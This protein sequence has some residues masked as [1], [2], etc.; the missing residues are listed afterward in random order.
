MSDH[1]ET[2]ASSQKTTLTPDEID[3]LLTSTEPDAEE[4]LREHARDIAHAAMASA[5]AHDYARAHCDTLAK[6][7]VAGDPAA[8]KMAAV[9][10]SGGKKSEDG[11]DLAFEELHIA[12][13]RASLA[14]CGW[15]ANLISVQCLNMLDAIKAINYVELRFASPTGDVRGQDEVLLTVQRV[16][17]PTP[18]ELRRAAEDREGVAKMETVRL[19]EGIEGAIN[20]IEGRATACRHLS[21]RTE[22]GARSV[23]A[24]AVAKA[25]A[26][27]HAVELPCA[28]LGLPAP[29]RHGGSKAVEADDGDLL[30]A[31][32]T[33]I[34]TLPRCDRSGCSDFATWPLD[35]FSRGC[36]THHEESA[37]AS[38]WLKGLR[39]F[40]YAPA[41][42]ALLA[43][44]VWIAL[45][46]VDGQ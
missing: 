36:D 34:D 2:D 42:R 26:Y 18:H 31:L 20:A 41:L 27:E 28:E 10:A 22:N 9:I 19:R 3:R 30:V 43:H 29:Q 8:E 35:D 40:A 13:G 32:R 33:V 25:V 24:R 16:N 37:A 45:T 6:L 23:H 5:R 11:G 12:H 44:P 46:N 7:V 17:H 38:P 1:H 4:R 14:T 15:V 39:E 21:G